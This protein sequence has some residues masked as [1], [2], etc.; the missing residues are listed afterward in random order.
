MIMKENIKIVVTK[1]VNKRL[2]QIYQWAKFK[3]LYNNSSIIWHDIK[4]STKTK[5]LNEVCNDND[6]IPKVEGII[7]QMI[8]WFFSLSEILFWSP[9]VNIMPQYFEPINV[10]IIAP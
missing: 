6:I 10:K 8:I 1:N 3:G 5:K 2:K 7:D 4:P 9:M